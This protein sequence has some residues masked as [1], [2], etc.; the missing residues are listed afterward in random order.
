MQ[1]HLTE[2]RL[3]AVRRFF[4]CSSKSDLLGCYTWCQALSGALLPLLNDFEVTLRNALH[5]ALSQFYAQTDSAPWMLP[6]AGPVHAGAPTPKT[7]HS[8][9]PQDRH[10]I[11]KFVD[12]RSRKGKTISQDDV[13]AS[14]SF[15]FWEQLVNGLG[16][17]NHPPAL[18]QSVLQMAFPYAPVGTQYGSEDFRNRLVRL[19]RSVRDVRNRV[20]HHDAIWG[21]PEFDAYGHIGFIPRRPR[22]TVVSAK[23]FAQRLVWI[24]SWIDP[25]IAAHIRRSEHWERLHKV[26]SR[27]ALTAY[28][29]R[30]GRAGCHEAV[31]KGGTRLGPRRT[32]HY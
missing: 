20:G 24:A 14:A 5:R 32:L 10:E 1:V 15:G 21:M 2:R 4:Q 27:C 29:R 6:L 13:V 26:L 12:R 11:H 3:A 8:M 7:P 23:L 30:A 31:L 22:H 9:P 25:E 16:R 17:S 19:L 28:R 18:Q